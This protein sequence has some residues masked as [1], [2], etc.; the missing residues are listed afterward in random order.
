MAV[1]IFL[2]VDLL[3]F[4]A[5]FCGSVLWALHRGCVSRGCPGDLWPVLPLPMQQLIPVVAPLF[6]G[7]EESGSCLGCLLM[8]QAAGKICYKS[9]K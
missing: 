9:K 1:L 6:L 7:M 8:F 2:T 3:Y 5:L 4:V